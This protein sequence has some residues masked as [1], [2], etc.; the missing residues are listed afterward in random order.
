MISLINRVKITLP[1]VT[2]VLERILRTVSGFSVLNEVNASKDNITQFKT[3]Y[4]SNLSD[5]EV[6]TIFNRFTQKQDSVSNKDIFKY[7]GLETLKTE[8]SKPSRKEK[9]E[10]YNTAGGKTRVNDTPTTR[11]LL[12][13]KYGNILDEDIEDIIK[14]WNLK[15]SDGAAS[16]DIFE[17][18]NL[19]SL[20][21]DIVRNANGEDI[22][23]EEFPEDDDGAETIFSDDELALIKITSYESSRK[24]CHE[25]GG[26]ASWCISYE[27]D[28][29]YWNQ[30]TSEGKEFIFLILKTGDKYA[31]TY[32]DGAHEV[33]DRADILT[34]AYKLVKDH[35][36]IVAPLQKAGVKSIK[37]A[38]EY[39]VTNDEIG[40]IVTEESSGLGGGVAT[41]IS[42]LDKNFEYR[43]I[44]K[45]NHPAMAIDHG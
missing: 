15:S 40:P 42:Y 32:V 34:S 11:T 30:Y 21:T 35:P 19:T 2:I 4:G 29:K 5:E 25:I 20:K 24:Y 26:S 12:R 7:S 17:Y 9:N 13:L 8:L 43:D 31:I 18:S 39:D 1:Q 28:E 14:S 22:S 41:I 27:T 38:T 44:D 33:Y 36:Q 3:K 10:I 16:N 6:T 37:N 23:I 45:H